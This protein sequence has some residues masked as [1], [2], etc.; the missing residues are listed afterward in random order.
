MAEHEQESLPEAQ[1]IGGWVVWE[2]K[3]R[4]HPSPARGVVGK[5]SKAK[6]DSR[7]ALCVYVLLFWCAARA[8]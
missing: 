2:A 8:R 4:I 7:Q 6:K 1:A 5:A 3:Q